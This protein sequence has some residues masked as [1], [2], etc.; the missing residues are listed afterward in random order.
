MPSARTLAMAQNVFSAVAGAVAASRLQRT[1]QKLKA[2]KQKVGVAETSAGGLI[3]ATL[4]AHP[5]A[6]AYFAG[7][8][9]V[10]TK[11]SKAKFLGLDAEKSKPT[12]TEPHAIELAQA[13]REALQC[14][15]AIGETGVAGPKP[16]SRGIS[17]GVCGLAVVGPDVVKRKTL[18][19]D[20]SLSDADAYGQPPKVLRPVAMK[21][22][23]DAALELLCDAVDEAHP[24]PGTPGA[25]G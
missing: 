8:V 25:T 23:E 15:W 13:M 1:L 12:A 19:P 6:S 14:D 4:L 3:A 9:V 17:P 21:T 7:G 22:F 24:D 16:N 5:G 11:A 10:Y 20:D 18:F 2:A